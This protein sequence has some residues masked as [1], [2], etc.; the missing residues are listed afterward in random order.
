MRLASGSGDNAVKICNVV[1]GQE[2][3]TVNIG[4]P[5]WNIL[6]DITGT[7]LHTSRGV[8]IS[9]GYTAGF[10]YSA[11]HTGFSKAQYPRLWFE[12]RPCM[13]YMEWRESAVVT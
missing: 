6:F 13:D 1:T 2:I 12:L 5:L 4:T 10:D 9:P 8:I 3:P 7:C 11:E